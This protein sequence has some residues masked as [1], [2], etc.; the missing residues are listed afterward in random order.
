ML[1]IGEVARQTGIAA[2]ALRY[3]EREGLIPRGDRR[4]GKRVYNED[5]LDRLALIGVC[6]G[7]GFTVAEMQTLIRGFG[8]RTPPGRRWRKLAADKLGELEARIAEV[9]RMKRV[10]EVVTRCECPT[11]EECS[12]AIRES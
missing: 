9:E 1:T 2:S 11:L 5:I 3:Y 7:A 4:G 10:L 8:R 6:K 12:R